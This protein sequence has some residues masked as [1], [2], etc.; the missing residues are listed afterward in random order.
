MRSKQ[1]GQLLVENGDVDADQVAQALKMQE[2]RGGLLGYILREQNWCE[3]QAIVNG[4]LKQVQ[5]TDVKCDELYVPPDVAGLVARETCEM[6]KLCPFERIG[7][8][9]CIVMGNPLNR[10]AISSIEETTRLKVKSFKA[11]W[12]KIHELIERTY[13]QEAAPADDLSMGGGSEDLS[14]GLETTDAPALG[15]VPSLELAEPDVPAAMDEPLELGGDPESKG[16]AAPKG[17]PSG[18]SSRR[19]KPQEPQQARIKGL[20]SLSDGTEA[21][22]INTDDRGLTKRRG[23]SLPTP[24]PKAKKNAKVNVDL[25]TLD[26]SEGE[27]VAAAGDEQL[28][29]HD[30]IAFAAPLPATRR[31]L[32][33]RFVELKAVKDS[34][35]YDDAGA[36]AEKTDEF[37][38]LIDTLPKAE[39]LAQ[40]IGEF[41]RAQNN[42]KQ[43]VV[44]AAKPSMAGRPVQLQPA[45]YEAV[46]P[47]LISEGEFQKLVGVSAEDPVGEWDWAFIAPGPVTVQPL[48][49]N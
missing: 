46:Q 43:S 47:T 33:E 32:G 15:D 49:E 38:D 2:E 45:P 36:P 17:I 25:D 39:V 30:E 28:E 18:I 11:V 20:D 22:M 48:E 16:I 5:V 34:Y 21:E 8:M 1:L 26:L 14:I 9:L 29:G 27:V 35:F 10:K 31:I 6:E 19:S 4:L 41:E 13:S 23:P 12:P 3:E 37:F 24:L 44:T 7:N 40:S 42:R